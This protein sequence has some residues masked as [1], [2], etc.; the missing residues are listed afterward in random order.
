MRKISQPLR[1]QL[2]ISKNL[3]NNPSAVDRRSCDLGA[4][5]PREH[6]ESFRLGSLRSTHY[7][8]S[9][10]TLAIQTKVLGEGLSE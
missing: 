2:F 6:G 3:R 1:R 7:V 5:K 8:Q 10:H 4:R 9:A